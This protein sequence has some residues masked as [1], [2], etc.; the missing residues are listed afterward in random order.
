MKTVIVLSVAVLANSLGSVCLSKG[1]KQF[2]AEEFLGGA[3]LLKVGWQILANPW[4]ILGVLLLITFLAAYLAAL[5]WADLSFVLPATAPGYIL[6]A[7]FS[8]IFLGEV[9]S[10]ARWGGILLIV[11]GT[12]L[13]GRTFSTAKTETP[14]DKSFERPFA[15]PA[16]NTFGGEPH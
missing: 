10:P 15:K 12:G 16:S 11:L 3:G 13:V 8:K 14:A 6:T 9:I 2:P 5:S 4:M 1:M 7:L